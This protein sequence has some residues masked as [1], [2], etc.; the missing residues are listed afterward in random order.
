M[1]G[2]DSTHVPYTYRDAHLRK[3]RLFN[4]VVKGR[5]PP[6]ETDF[7][8]DEWRSVCAD[9]YRH[10]IRWWRRWSVLVLVLMLVLFPLLLYRSGESFGVVVLIGT[11]PLWGLVLVFLPIFALIRLCFGHI[12][13]A[14]VTDDAVVNALL[15]RHRCP[16]CAYR[17]PRA[18]DTARAT[19]SECG[20]VWHNRAVRTSHPP[21]PSPCTSPAPSQAPP[22]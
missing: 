16:S 19:C 10:R 2:S 22:R 5:Q 15:A 21:P 14:N 20:A 17:L 3:V 9:I 11:L 6:A 18:D 7:S 12:A 4:P 13:F 8:V 1:P